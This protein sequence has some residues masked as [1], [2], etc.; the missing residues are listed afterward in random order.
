MVVGDNLESEV[1]RIRAEEGKNIWFCGGADILKTFIRLDLV[2]EYVLSVHPIILMAGK[3]LFPEKKVPENLTL[4]A[5]HEMP[6]GVMILRYK[7]K[8]RLS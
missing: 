3:P 4:T 7:P 8:S 1:Q 2:D 5:K 6:S